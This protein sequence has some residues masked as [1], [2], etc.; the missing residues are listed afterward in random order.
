MARRSD[1]EGMILLNVLLVVA[2]ASATVLIMIAGQDIELQRSSRMRD[3][4]QAG[5]YARAGELSAITSLRRDG[6]VA[7]GTDNLAEPWAAVAQTAVDVPRGRFALAIED[8]QARFNLNALSGGQATAIGLFQRIGAAVGVA[9]A[10][11]IRIATVVRIAGPLTD[12]RL[13]IAA[14]VAQADLARLEPFVTLLPPDATINLNTANQTLLSLVLNDPAAAQALISQRDRV[15]Y[16][17][18]ADLA[19]FGSAPSG[20]GF[21]S[22]HFRTTTAVTVGDVDQVLTSRLA[23]VRGEGRV[24]VIVVGRR[25]GV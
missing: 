10:T 17:V 25:S 2:M 11:L 6:I 14:G 18:P 15:G 20:V 19:P 13:L 3:V 21:T 4:A 1:R 24:D 22:D 8:E 16:L 7:A 5:A 12:D 9:P 23:R